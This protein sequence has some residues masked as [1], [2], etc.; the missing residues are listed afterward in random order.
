MIVGR[1]SDV[2]E[3]LSII[4]IYGRGR[5]AFT[6]LDLSFIFTLCFI[7]YDGN[8]HE[9]IIGSSIDE[10][11]E[12]NEFQN[13]F[14]KP[15][16]LFDSYIFYYNQCYQNLKPSKLIAM[17][18]IKSTI[19]SQI[20]FCLLTSDLFQLGQKNDLKKLKNKSSQYLVEKWSYR[21]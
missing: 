11:S 12:L 3:G 17:L 13:L 15:H 19:V 6:W 1:L 10:I 2:V 16:E 18:L 14:E 20:I 9:I 7:M 8:V 4:I 5:L 21:D